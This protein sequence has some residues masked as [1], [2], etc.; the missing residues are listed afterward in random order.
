M[1]DAAAR[2]L[3]ATAA[4]RTIALPENGVEIALLDWGGNGP[5]VLLHHANGFCKGVWGLVADALRDRYRVL[6]MDARGHGDSSKPSGPAAYAWDR[7]AE[8][9]AGVASRLAAEHGDGRVAL[10]IGNSFGGTALV[11]AAA[12]R[13]DLFGQLV[14]V[15]PVVPPPPS[16]VR[17]PERAAHMHRLVEGARKRRAHFPSRAEARAQWAKRKLFAHWDRRALALYAEDG[18]RDS[19]GGGVELKCPPEIEATIFAESGSLDLFALARQLV[20][21]TLMLW[22]AQGDFPRPLYEVL[23]SSMADGR[24]ETLEAGHLTPMERPD[25]VVEAALRFAQTFAITC[26]A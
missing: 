20:T 5:L 8:D 1:P 9:V 22:A 10:G 4:R 7:F 14:L 21:P 26:S 13:P 12:R 16:V 23:A 2:A 24:V 18:L 11:G 17:T 15:D 25:L 3:L 6:S 19:S